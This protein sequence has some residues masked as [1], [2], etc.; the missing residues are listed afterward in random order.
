[1]EGESIEL[2]LTQ[3]TAGIRTGPTQI[4]YWTVH[5]HMVFQIRQQNL[6]EALGKKT[7][8]ESGLQW[9]DHGKVG[10]A[11]LAHKGNTGTDFF[12]RLPESYNR[13]MAVCLFIGAIDRSVL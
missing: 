3:L 6:A 2:G 12:T 4:D 11:V 7:L 5:N 10:E 1:M 8:I 13:N 9:D